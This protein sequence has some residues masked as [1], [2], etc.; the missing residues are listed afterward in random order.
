M[1]RTTKDY[2]NGKIYAI[3]NTENDKIYI[4]ST[5]QPLC[6][7]MA[8]HRGYAN[9][10]NSK[11]AQNMREVGIDRFYIELLE[12][13][14]CQTQEQLNKREGELIREH[15]SFID[16]YNSLI[17][18][19]IEKEYYVENADK[20]RE[21]Q[22][23]WQADNAEK[24]RESK[25]KYYAENAETLKEYQAKYR[26]ENKDVINARRREKYASKKQRKETND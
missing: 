11:F 22:A 10:H 4:G 18:G 20:I 25:A 8:T 14:P 9:T 16:G 17:A 23:K 7:S 26:A 1:P 21:Y 5:T 15:N 6:K 3:R 24:I 19:R 13:Y 2:S 12:L